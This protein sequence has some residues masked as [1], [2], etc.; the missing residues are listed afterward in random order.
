MTRRHLIA[1]AATVAIGL[2]GAAGVVAAREPLVIR[3]SPAIAQPPAFVTV[4]TDVEAHDDN[5]SLEVSA[6][7]PDFFTSSRL[8]LEGSKAPRF[9]EFHFDNLPSG[10]YKVTVVLMGSQGPRAS[11]SKP[12][13]VG[14]PEDTSSGGA[15][16]P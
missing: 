11:V 8:P 15:S 9:N 1:F 10:A 16:N 4:R 2:I 12:V 5:R 14:I 3:V 6:E 7:G 13:T